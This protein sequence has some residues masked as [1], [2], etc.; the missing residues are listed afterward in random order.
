MAEKYK[1][2]SSNLDLHLDKTNYTTSQ[3][4]I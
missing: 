1:D 2:I 3:D 4:E